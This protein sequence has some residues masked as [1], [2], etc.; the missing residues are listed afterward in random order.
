MS[1]LKELKATENAYTDSNY[2]ESKNDKYYLS[3][4]RILKQ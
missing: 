4:A 2:I 1:R 3:T